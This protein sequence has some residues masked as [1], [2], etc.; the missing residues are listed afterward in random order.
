VPTAILN[1]AAAALAMRA[2]R[3]P[4][5]AGKSHPHATGFRRRV[6]MAVVT[7]ALTIWAL[8]PTAQW[9]T[10][11]ARSA[12][13]LSRETLHHLC[14]WLHGHTPHTA[15]YA[16]RGGSP[17]YAVLA[18]WPLGN[19][20]V[21]IAR[22]PNVANN[23]VGWRENRESNLL[24]YRFFV[25]DDPARAA[26]LLRSCGVRYVIA[27]EPIESG[28]LARAADILGIEHAVLFSARQ[29]GGRPV[30]APTPAAIRSMAVRLYL[31]DAQSLDPFRLVYESPA[32][33]S[34]AGVPT[35]V[36]KVFEFTGGSP[37]GPDG[38]RRSTGPALGVANARSLL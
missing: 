22:R 16:L 24:P 9:L 30:Y 8:F 21:Y 15:G 32:R 36:Y 35:P 12:P 25:E 13:R 7:A 6:M 11:Y 23:F 27:G 3:F 18:E 37:P 31:D 29:Q 34:V 38:G 14:L 28:F 33:Q 10:R 20:L 17:A 5:R 19:A 2:A 26:A 4:F 1:A